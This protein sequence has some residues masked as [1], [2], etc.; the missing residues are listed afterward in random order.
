MAPSSILLIDA[1]ALIHRTFH[2]LPPLV[3]PE[4]RPTGAL[5]G[6]ARILLNVLKKDRFTHIFAAFDRPEPTFRKEAFKEYKAHRPPAPDELVSQLIEARKLFQAFGIP[7]VEEPK[8]EADDIIGTLAVRFAGTDAHITILTGDLDTLQLVKDPS[9]AVETF[10]KGVSETMIYDEAAVE[11]RYGLPPEK[12]TDWKGLVGDTSDNIPGVRGIGPKTAATLLKEFDSLE[13]M[14]RSMPAAHRFASKVLPYKK[15]ALLAKTLTTIV[16]DVPLPVS[17]EEGRFTE[18]PLHSLRP[19]FTRMGF[20]S[21]LKLPSQESSAPLQ[22]KKRAVQKTLHDFP[23]GTVFI[24]DAQDARAR[25]SLLTGKGEKVAYDWKGI[26]KT[27]GDK[28]RDIVEPLF[29]LSVA[30]WLID[31][32]EK[33]ISH[34][35]LLVRFLPKTAPDDAALYRFLKEKLSSYALEY[36]FT[37]IE[38]PL[39]PVLAVMERSGIAVDRKKLEALAHTMRE[40]LKK[41]EARIY[42]EAGG[43]FNVNSPRQVAGV[44]FEKLGLGTAK[45]QKTGTGQRRTGKNILLEL[46]NVHPIVPLLL[47]Y[48]E[49]FKIFSSFVEPL[50]GAIERDGRVHTTFLQTG[51][52]TGRLSS[53]HPNLQNIPQES[54]WA[55]KLRNAFVAPKGTVLVSFD[56]S[57]LE[58]RLLA[59]V[60]EDKELHTAFLEGKDIHRLTAEKVFGAHGDGITLSMRR[61]AKTLNFGIVFGMGARAFAASSGLS[62]TEAKRFMEVYFDEFPRVREWQERVKEEAKT[63]GY[64]TNENGRRRWFLHAAARGHLGEVER[65]AVNMP[66]QSLEADIIKMAMVAASAFIKDSGAERTRM[67]LSIHD[68]LLFEIPRGMLNTLVPEL[69]KRMESVIRLSVPLRVDVSAGVD[70]GSMEPVHHDTF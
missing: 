49:S 53:E 52:A 54:K 64:V 62:L 3:G 22:E 51:T 61:T 24:K 50:M 11:A 57:Q 40:E 21:L 15:D 60:S 56:Y 14:F 65:A 39:V 69:K 19:Y 1:H 5:Y 30:G 12:L 35:A 32:E 45:K 48:R 26:L 34:E 23:P 68:E 13:D 16:T 44:L 10:K 66:L 59:H 25:F 46:G 9:I 2:A 7:V 38:M 58:L 4:G 42:H 67:V 36:V 28:A 41:L 17:L 29:D 8:V 18:L 33:E 6:L 43:A 70:W 55:P 27:L 63:N 31:P 20:E 37:T 47:E